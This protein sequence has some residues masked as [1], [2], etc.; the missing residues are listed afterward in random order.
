MEALK[1]GGCLPPCD[2]PE[3]VVGLFFVGVGGFSVV[4]LFFAGLDGITGF[5]QFVAQNGRQF[6]PTARREALSFCS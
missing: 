2:L 4:F 3:V 6:Y 1:G 5:Q